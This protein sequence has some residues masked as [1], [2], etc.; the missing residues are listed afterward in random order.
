MFL[1]QLVMYVS[2]HS[3]NGSMNK[4]LVQFINECNKQLM[5]KEVNKISILS[6]VY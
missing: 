1:K 6:A 5:D 2:L 4:K 3:F